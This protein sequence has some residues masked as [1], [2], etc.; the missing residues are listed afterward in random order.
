MMGNIWEKD[1]IRTEN[2]VRIDDF[3]GENNC[4]LEVEHGLNTSWTL[5]LMRSLADKIEGNYF[6]D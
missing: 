6:L 1:D 2:A 5:L 4:I 3:L